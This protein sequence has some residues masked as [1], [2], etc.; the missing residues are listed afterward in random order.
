[1]HH[2]LRLTSATFG[3][4]ALYYFLF[5]E[6]NTYETLLALMLILTVI[7][8]YFFWSDPVIGSDINIYD[9]V[10]AKLTLFL[11]IS[12]TL[13]KRGFTWQYISIL[14]LIGISFYYSDY[15]SSIQWCCTEHIHSHGVFHVLCTIGT[16]FAFV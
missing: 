6:K 7:L 5:S 13:W 3:L 11:F 14:F 12:Y 15:Y 1:M 4:P 9:A 2:A 10:V 8:S 16:F